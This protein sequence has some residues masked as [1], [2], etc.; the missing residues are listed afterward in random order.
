MSKKT[1]KYEVPSPENVYDWIEIELKRLGKISSVER[2]PRVLCSLIGA[3]VEQLAG[4]R[5]ALEKSNRNG[6][7]L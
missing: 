4:I 1:D 2:V 6:D 5:E 3:V 7:K